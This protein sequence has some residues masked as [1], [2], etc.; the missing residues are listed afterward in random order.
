MY[1]FW[2]LWLAS[3]GVLMALALGYAATVPMMRRR[4]P[5]EPDHPT[6]HGMSCEDVTFSSTD[7]V[8][9]GGWWIPAQQARGTVIM[10]P[11]QNGSADKDVPQT[12]PLHDAGFNVLLFDF[13]AHGRSEG[14]LVT[15]GVLE[16]LDLRAA[17]DYVQQERGAERAGVMG[18]SMG[19]AVALLV[20]AED[21]RIAALVLDGAY[22]RLAGILPAW[23]RLQGLP[24][25]LA[26][27]AAW[28]VMLIGSLRA[29]YQLY[30]ANPLDL[31]EGIKAPALF[32]HGEDDPFVTWDELESLVER[33]PGPTD[34]WR[35]RHGMHRSAFRDHAEDYN[36]RVVAW[37]TEHVG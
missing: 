17:L 9:L 24:G 26:R 5:D 27:G 37:F 4:V 25:P 31:A 3:L 35:V 7:E 28:V 29:R 23:V 2:F 8:E 16:Q 21:E 34:V 18:F 14:R 36:H 10:C 32:I 19:A 11:G 33:I 15:L 13:R 30:H 22:P 6:L 1:L 12:K 20:A